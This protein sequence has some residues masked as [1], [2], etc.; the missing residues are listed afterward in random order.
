MKRSYNVDVSNGLAWLNISNTSYGQKKGRESNC[1]FDSQP[2]K[3]NNHLNFLAHRWRVTYCWKALNEGYN[4]VLNLVIIKGLH[5]KLCT[6]KV[7]RIPILRISGLPLGSLG[8]KCHLGAS[9]MAK[10]RVYYKR[11]GGGFPKV[12]AVVSLVSLNLPLARPN[13]KN[14]LAMH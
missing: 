10:Q 3:V 11:E 2:L 12:R 6:P 14:V 9:P 13:T 7:A 8:A 5:T 1:Q 4:F